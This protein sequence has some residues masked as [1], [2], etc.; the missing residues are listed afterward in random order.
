VAQGGNRIGAVILAN[1]RASPAKSSVLGVGC[2]VLVV[3]LL[4]LVVGGPKTAEAE[5]G[6]AL[7]PQVAVGA[8]ATPAAVVPQREPRLPR[9]R[10][11]QTIARDPFSAAWLGDDVRAGD[12]PTDAQ[13]ELTLQMVMTA[14]G[15]ASG[16]VA[17][18]SGV[19]VYPGSRIGGYEVLDIA[20]GAVTLRNGTEK[21]QL[22]MP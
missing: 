2:V 13:G 3:L 17:V 11:R 22:R 9:P 7:V 15:T 4:R 20:S 12:A 18:I 19:M 10:L 8:S 5:E 14:N 16:A 1:L 21:V 6:A